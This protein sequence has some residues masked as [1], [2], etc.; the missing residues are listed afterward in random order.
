MGEDLTYAK[1]EVVSMP[2]LNC[3]IV[4]LGGDIRVIRNIGYIISFQYMKGGDINLY[5]LKHLFILN[6]DSSEHVRLEI[7]DRVC[8]LA[9]AKDF[10][11]LFGFDFR[12]TSFEDE[13]RAI[14]RME[15]TGSLQFSNVGV[16]ILLYEDSIH[17]YK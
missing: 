3:F 9:T 17:F 16:I 2:T 4:V 7:L 11:F 1:E 8:V 15:A 5:Y 13:H 6:C 14:I 10:L 12:F